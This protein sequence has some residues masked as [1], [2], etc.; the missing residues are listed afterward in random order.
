MLKYSDILRPVIITGT[1]AAD[2]TKVLQAAPIDVSYCILCRFHAN[3]ATVVIAN[4]FYCC[5]AIPI[6]YLDLGGTR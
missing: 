2:R 1:S 6:E 4:F 5:K 3:V